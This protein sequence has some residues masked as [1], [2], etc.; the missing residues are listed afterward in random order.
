MK[1]LFSNSFRQ[2]NSLI[3]KPGSYAVELVDIRSAPSKDFGDGNP[4]RDRLTFCFK[5]EEG[6]PVNRTMSATADP[7]GRLIEFVRQMAGSHQPTAED[8]SSGEKL[9]VYLSSLIG[10][11][12]RANIIPSRDGRFNDIVSISSLPEKEAA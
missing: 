7:R 5:T 2:Q 8:M 6:A 9:T 4:P 3:L 12:F 11:K 10:K 1:N